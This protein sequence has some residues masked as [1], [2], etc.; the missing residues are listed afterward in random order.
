MTVATFE[1]LVWVR[2]STPP[3][4]VAASMPGVDSSRRSI[5]SLTA[6]V[7]SCEAPSGRRMATNTVP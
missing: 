1:L 4:V 5:S 2:R 6:M 3:S 7:R